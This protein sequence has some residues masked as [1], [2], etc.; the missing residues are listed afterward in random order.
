MKIFRGDE[1]R[2]II[3]CYVIFYTLMIVI[4]LDNCQQ[5]F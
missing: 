2:G 5:A 4:T 1:V 3:I